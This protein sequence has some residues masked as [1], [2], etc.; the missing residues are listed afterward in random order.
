[1]KYLALIFFLLISLLNINAQKPAFPIKPAQNGRYLVDNNNKPF[2]YQ[3]ETPWLIFVNLNKKEMGELMDIRINQGFTVIQTMAL[4]TGTNVNGDK[5]FENNDFTKPNLAYFEH[6]RKGIQIAEQKGLL[7]GVALAWKGCCGGDWTDI[8]L[9]NGTKNCREYGRFLGKYFADCKNLFWIQGG[10]ADP[11]GHTDHYREMALGIKEFMPGAMQTYHASSGH[12]SS[13][14][15]N[16]LDNSWL[17]FS[18]TYTYFHNK[19]NVWIYLCGW[20]ELPEVY[21]M[22][23][24]EYRKFPVKPFVLGESQYEGED[25]ASCRPF[26]WP[27]IVRRQAYWSVLSGSCGHAYGSWCWMVNKDWRKVENDPG[28][29]QM[30]HVK[31]LFESFEWYKLTPDLNGEIINSGA[32]TYGKTDYAVASFIPDGNLIVAYFPP[33]GKEARK[34]TINTSKMNKITKAQWFNPTNGQYIDI[35]LPKAKNKNQYDLN[36][37]GDNGSEANDWILVL[38]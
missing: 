5:P 9:K 3:A 13:D 2:F 38:N 35:S 11:Q 34:M 25:S 29:K 33:S 1:M 26:S 21:E 36:T 12:S 20:G 27:E 32:G 30:L 31:N 6:I 37:I 4:T 17:N 22:N 28:A 8:I 14:V 18:W 23:H 19:H 24:I 10:D 16:Y 15:M 7:V